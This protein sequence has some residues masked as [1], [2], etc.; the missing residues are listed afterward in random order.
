MRGPSITTVTT[1]VSTIPLLF[2]FF[3]FCCLGDFCVLRLI[4]FLVVYA[5]NLVLTI[6]KVI[7]A[8]V[9]TLILGMFSLP[10]TT[11]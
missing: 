5:D 1:Q 4:G 7:F 3:F 9:V 2:H 11:N 10:V 6:A 8:V